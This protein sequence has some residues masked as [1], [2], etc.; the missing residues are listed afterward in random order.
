MTTTQSGPHYYS[1]PGH[2]P[3]PGYKDFAPKKKKILPP[4]GLTNYP[5]PD[6]NEPVVESNNNDYYTVQAPYVTYDIYSVNGGNTAAVPEG[7]NYA[8]N[9]PYSN[10]NYEA[11]IKPFHVQTTLNP[12]QPGVNIYELGINTA[13]PNNNNLPNAYNTNRP[14]VNIE[15]PNISTEDKFEA[16]DT[17][18]SPDEVVN[19]IVGKKWVSNVQISC[20]FSCCHI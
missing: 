1:P 16:P 14:N 13:R 11:T 12:F 2:S 7:E 5:F 17:E 6:D 18:I 10:R 20:D 4:S 15:R 9:D 8:T 19:S 3:P